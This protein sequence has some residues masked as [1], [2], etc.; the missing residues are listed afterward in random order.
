MTD[1]LILVA[2][3]VLNGVAQAIY[4]RWRTKPRTRKRR[5][6]QAQPARPRY[7]MHPSPTGMDW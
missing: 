4:R 3:V 1:L 2:L 6:P 7:P 5:V